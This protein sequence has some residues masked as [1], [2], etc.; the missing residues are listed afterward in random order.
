M[1]GFEGVGA[2]EMEEVD[3]VVLRADSGV[4]GCFPIYGRLRERERVSEK[5]GG[6]GRES[7]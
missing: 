3:R 5:K 4:F 6:S 7:G 1:D 2:G